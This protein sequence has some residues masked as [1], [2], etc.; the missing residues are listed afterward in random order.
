MLLGLELGLLL[1]LVSSA[2]GIAWPGM[3]L[4]ES[5]ESLL[6]GK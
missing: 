4:M 2:T 3:G 1:P 5:G 6:K